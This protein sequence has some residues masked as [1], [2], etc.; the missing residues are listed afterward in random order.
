MKTTLHV[1]VDNGVI[2]I[3]KLVLQNGADCPGGLSTF[4][5]LSY[6]TPLRNRFM[7]IETESWFILLSVLLKNS[8]AHGDGDGHIEI[9]KSTLR[10]GA[11]VDGAFSCDFGLRSTV[12]LLN[13]SLKLVQNLYL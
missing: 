12:K 7:K 5:E 1:A 11:K 9:V 8:M 13:C 3:A 10:N 6:L 2:E 4:S